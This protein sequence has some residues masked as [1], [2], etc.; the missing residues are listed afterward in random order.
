[1]KFN[2][3]ALP[4][5]AELLLNIF[6]SVID[7]KIQR[8][9]LPPEARLH[10]EDALRRA[11]EA[12]DVVFEPVHS[13]KPSSSEVKEPKNGY[14]EQDSVVPGVLLG[15]EKPPGEI[16]AG[17][18]LQ[19]NSFSVPLAGFQSTISSQQ[20]EKI[21]QEDP[22]QTLHIPIESTS[23][24]TVMGFKGTA[25]AQSFH[26]VPCSPNSPEF[27]LPLPQLNEYLR[28]IDLD[29]NQEFL[30]IFD[31]VDFPE[32]PLFDPLQDGVMP[33]DTGN[34][35]IDADQLNLHMSTWDSDFLTNELSLDNEVAEPTAK[36][37]SKHD[38]NKG[39]PMPCNG[40][41][42]DLP[43]NLQPSKRSRLQSFGAHSSSI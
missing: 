21:L 7:D 6:N 18:S 19:G 2:S 1:V 40:L 31:Y 35:E 29:Q 27:S 32:P 4:Y 37:K 14:L 16:Y 17:E 34:S 28:Q 20:P 13:V 22:L 3:S 25:N 5:N 30:E 23:S 24:D 43:G 36:W 42:M 15:V 12:Q 26:T 8:G 41:G 39:L 10:C 38:G 33:F 9:T 11:L